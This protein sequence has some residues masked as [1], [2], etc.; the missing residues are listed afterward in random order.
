[1]TR[2]YAPETF[3]NQ[4]E[5]R[6]VD[7]DWPIVVGAPRATRA[8]RKACDRALRFFHVWPAFED[9]STSIGRIF[10]AHCA[11]E[12]GTDRQTAKRYHVGVSAVV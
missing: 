7:I 9:P 2:M 5:V 12:R 10:D 6:C 1:M 4:F 3:D 8:S 11:L